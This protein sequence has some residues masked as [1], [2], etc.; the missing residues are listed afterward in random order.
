[1]EKQER[2]LENKVIG[3]LA[4]K[5]MESTCA[6][7]VTFVVSIVLARLVPPSDYGIIAMVTIFITIANVF[8]TSGFGNALVQKQDADN[9]DFSTVFYFELIFSII[10]YV[11]VFILAPVVAKFYGQPIIT[12]VMRVLAL[13]LILAGVNS[14]QHAFISK[15]MLF[16]KFFL[17]TI[18]GTIV[19]AI[20]GI[21]MAYMGYGI[22]A[23]VAQYLVNSTMDTIILW[24]T[25]KWRPIRCFSATRLVPLINFGWK[26]LVDQLLSSVYENLRSMVIGKAYTSQ[27]LAFYS[28]GIQ[29][30]GLI[31]NNI[32]ASISSVLFPTLS[33]LQGNKEALKK[34]LKKSIRIG[35]LLLSPILIGMYVC[36]YAI[37]IILLTDKWIE[38]IPYLKI[39]CIYYLFFPITTANLEA[40]LAIGKS[41]ISLQLTIIKRI[42]GV[43]LVFISIKFGVIAVA[44][45]DLVVVLLAVAL[46]TIY[47]SKYLNYSMF[48]QI[49]DVLPSYISSLLMGMGVYFIR[50]YMAEPNTIIALMIQV[51]V[52]IILYIFFSLIINREDISY[53]FFKLKNFIKKEV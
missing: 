34:G 9:I 12:P 41:D 37:I 11:I 28:K 35:S 46:N 25:V 50:N 44:L 52:G 8:V 1:M 53:L 3:G 17:S 5:F 30:P 38:C 32:N 47:I 4:W 22:W 31:V 16:R 2:S 36:S 43:V 19:S 13:K 29:I 18:V 6:Q 45:S 21:S 10:I 33:K 14:V 26:L 40:L 48:D 49:K 42:V 27:D 20:V 7:L 39:A 51:M 24:I 23:L 15:K